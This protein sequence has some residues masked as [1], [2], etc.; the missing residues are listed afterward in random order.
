[1][2][3]VTRSLPQNLK[4]VRSVYLGT[5]VELERC[6]QSV[7]GSFV[8]NQC[9]LVTIFMVISTITIILLYVGEP[10]VPH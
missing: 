1:M 6:K 7:G 9:S 8:T 5:T 4:R 3:H 2:P 10:M